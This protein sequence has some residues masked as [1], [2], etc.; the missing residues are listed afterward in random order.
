[1]LLAI[2]T[3][4]PAIDQNYQFNVPN[5]LGCQQLCSNEP[6]SAVILQSTFHPCFSR[7]QGDSLP[8]NLSCQKTA[9]FL[10]VM[11]RAFTSQFSLWW[12]CT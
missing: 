2:L 10:S 8:C 4:P 1:M 9:D 12:S 3:Q 5:S 6:I 11:A 7:L